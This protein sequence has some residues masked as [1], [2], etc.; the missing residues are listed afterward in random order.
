MPGSAVARP[1]AASGCADL[2]LREV[3]PVRE[4][5]PGGVVDVREPVLRPL[6]GHRHHREG[7]EAGAPLHAVGDAVA[8][9][10]VPVAGEEDDP[11]PGPLQVADDS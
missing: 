10:N 7:L 2:V 1:G 8:G 9:L 11:P 4:R 5:P 6:D 3:D